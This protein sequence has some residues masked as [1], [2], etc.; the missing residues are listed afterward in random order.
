M[1]I[2]RLSKRE[3][4]ALILISTILKFSALYTLYTVQSSLKSHLL[5]VTLYLEIY[6]IRRAYKTVCILL[7]KV[8]LGEGGGWKSHWLN[9]EKC[10]RFPF[11]NELKNCNKLPFVNIINSLHRNLALRGNLVFW[12]TFFVYIFLDKLWTLLWFYRV[13]QYNF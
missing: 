10:S 5:W 8:G 3:D 1:L 11:V 12:S 9:G 13:P 7:C 2:L 6:N 4:Q